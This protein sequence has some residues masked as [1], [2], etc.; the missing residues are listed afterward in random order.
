M[1]RLPQRWGGAGSPETSASAGTSVDAE[2]TSSFAA[3]SSAARRCFSAASRAASA[4]SSSPRST[5]RSCSA[6]ALA[7]TSSLRAPQ[8]LSS[9]AALAALSSSRASCS[10]CGGSCCSSAGLP[11]GSRGWEL[12]EHAFGVAGCAAWGKATPIGTT[13]CVDI[14]PLPLISTT[15]RS[16][17]LSPSPRPTACSSSRV[18]CEMWMQLG[19]PWD[20]M[21]LAMF[22]V[23]PKKQ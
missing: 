23:S 9:A 12:K 11:G 19:A 14:W 5:Q 22:T 16:T 7:S 4:A 2:V 1:S 13:R 21:R 10:R 17:V 15:P 3:R 20:S 18:L 8:A 6:A